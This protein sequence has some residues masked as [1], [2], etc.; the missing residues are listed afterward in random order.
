MVKLQRSHA[1]G[2]TAKATAIL[3]GL[4]G[5]DPTVPSIHTVYK[6]SEHLRGLRIRDIDTRYGHP[7]T[8]LTLSP[9]GSHTKVWIRID[10]YPD[11]C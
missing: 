2:S 3:E 9:E 6:A 4:G 5:A 1:E 11:I 8:H 10:R 7:S